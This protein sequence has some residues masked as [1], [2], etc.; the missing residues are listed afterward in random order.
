MDTHNPDTS[1]LDPLP[2]DPA[3]RRLRVRYP[4][5][6][7]VQYRVT[8]RE[9]E[10]TGGSGRTINM[11]SSGILFATED[12]VAPGTR[13]QLWVSWPAK[14]DH[15]CP[16]NLVLRGKVVRAEHG[17]VAVKIEKREFRTRGTQPSQ[18]FEVSPRSA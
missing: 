14:L 10:I 9:S 4:I 15:K 2:R 7:A 1:M 12:P 6:C 13:I 16:M 18:P 3:D 8:G 11:S 5:G 17:V